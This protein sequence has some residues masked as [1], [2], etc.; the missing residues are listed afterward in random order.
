MKAGITHRRLVLACSMAALV[1]AGAVIIT[2]DPP[3]QAT[4]TSTNEPAS[5]LA[6]VAGGDPTS[7]TRSGILDN[8]ADDAGGATGA[9]VAY[10]SASQRWLYLSDADLTDAVALLT[11]PL[12]APRLSRD[13][14]AEVRAAR[15]RLAA[16]PGRVWW[17][18]R[19]MA[20]RV[21]SISEDMATVN[22]WTLTVLSAEDVAA[23][24]SEWV[25]VTVDLVWLD[26]TWRVDGTRETPGPTPLGGPNDQPWDASTFDSALT[27][28]TRM[29][30]EPVT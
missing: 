5:S 26:G 3:T 7:A 4:R 19:P 6:A 8:F 12:A 17:L 29:D 25:T 16:S 20:W 18:V 21:E 15:E 10:A 22:V 2:V 1:V 23:P 24:Q 28:F 9:A 30:G 13:A 14:V 27:G 11:T